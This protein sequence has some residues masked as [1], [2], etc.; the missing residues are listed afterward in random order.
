M[1][2]ASAIAYVLFFIT[3]AVVMVAWIT[4]R[5]WVFYS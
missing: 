1:G 2:Y 3:L 5:Q 4:Q